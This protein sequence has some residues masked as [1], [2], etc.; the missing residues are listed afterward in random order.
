MCC[1]SNGGISDEWGKLFLLLS[2]LQ[3]ET[4]TPFTS[5]NNALM[6]APAPR[7]PHKP[8]SV[9]AANCHTGPWGHSQW[10]PLPGATL[11]SSLGGLGKGAKVCWPMVPGR[12]YI[13]PWVLGAG[14]QRCGEAG[15]AS[16]L[17]QLPGRGEKGASIIHTHQRRAGEEVGKQECQSQPA[18]V[19][20]GEGLGG[21]DPEEPVPAPPPRGFGLQSGG[22]DS[23]LNLG[24][25]SPGLASA[26]SDKGQWLGRVYMMHSSLEHQAPGR[27]PCSSSR[28]E[29]GGPEV[30]WGTLRSWVRW[31]H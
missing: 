6:W 2:S 7:S 23:A 31:C 10:L 5:A 19:G 3:K 21:L 4:K 22:T 16:L 14:G 25:A 24:C 9:R 20:A 18:A 15:S 26:C 11:A 28:K 27:L 29:G 17:C 1:Y 13:R 30:K 8:G 12:M